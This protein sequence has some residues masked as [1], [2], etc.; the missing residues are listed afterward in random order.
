M[1]KSLEERRSQLPFPTSGLVDNK[2]EVVFLRD[3]QAEF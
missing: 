3:L 2:Q 1:A